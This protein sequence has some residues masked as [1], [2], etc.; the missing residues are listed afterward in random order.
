M[1]RLKRKTVSILVVL[2]MLAALLIPAAMPAAAATTSQT[3]SV[4][5]IVQP[6]YGQLTTI[7]ING[8][9]I[10]GTDQIQVVLPSGVNFITGTFS[11]GTNSYN[12]VPFSVYGGAVSETVTQTLST[13]MVGDAIWTPQYIPDSQQVP[14]GVSLI[15]VD[16]LQPQL[17]AFTVKSNGNGNG[18]Y[19]RINMP[20]SVTSA[21]SGP[22]QA[23]VQDNTTAVTAGKVTIGNAVTGGTVTTLTTTA[24]VA[25]NS[26]D[27]VS[28]LINE[29]SAGALGQGGGE[30][31][32]D[33]PSH[34]TW[35][36]PQITLAGGFPAGAVTSSVTTN[37]SGNSRMV[38]QV[39]KPS[40][41]TPGSILVNTKI[42]ADYNAPTGDITAT[43]GGTDP[44][45]T[46]T[47]A[48]VGTCGDYNVT[49]T[50]GN[51]PTIYDGQT[52]QTVGTFTIAESVKNTLITGRS[53]SLTLPGGVRWT[54]SNLP[55]PVV[56]TGSAQLLNPTLSSDRQTVTYEIQNSGGSATTF[57]FQQGEVD[58]DSTVTPGTLSVSI[59][60]SGV[61]QT[62][63][64]AKIASP[65]TA[66]A[67]G[68]IPDVTIG[69]PA[70]NGSDFTIT[71]AAAGAIMANYGNG[72]NQ[73]YLDIIAPS[74]VTF[75]SIP[76]IKVTS[77][78][79]NLS[80]SGATLT[81]YN[82]VLN[83]RISIPVSNGSNTASTITVSNV[84]LNIDNT[85]GVGPVSLVLGG[86]A[87][88]DPSTLMVK[89]SNG[90]LIPTGT[91]LVN[92]SYV[93]SVEVANCNTSIT[94]GT[95]G[96]GTGGTAVFTI[97][98]TSYTVNGRTYTMDVAP[99]TQNG[100]TFVP[101]RYAAMALGVNPDNILYQSG[102]VTVIKGS[103]VVQM[104]LGSYSMRINGADITMDV[105]VNT[106]NGRTMLPLRWLGMALGATFNW[107]AGTQTVT[108]SNQ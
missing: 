87:L 65:V 35:A 107:N 48:T 5:N 88:V 57:Q 74:G 92:G 62:V 19:V 20:V 41:G 99:Y 91:R 106:V 77:G 108:V 14:N 82:G 32:I 38:L 34:F 72:K 100:R 79:L 73:A 27:N 24:T 102:V 44:G 86:S 69:R 103:T 60:G 53:L 10:S 21:A 43:F 37:S 71:E 49:T 16:T 93:A 51:V 55:I 83:S 31:H 47:T 45:F 61:N 40:K 70:Q 89:D 94:T 46:A 84:K 75:A 26:S 64:I 63:D 7:K 78:D 39:V 97:G 29:N 33:L 85:V 18:G 8:L 42:S 3:D 12:S 4:P 9:S 95:G 13:P 2:A 67:T 1:Y 22:I 15:S 98:N 17:L 25:Q 11:D 28:F 76:T 56:Q 50:Q 52:G 58:V 104:T 80:P 54:E 81:D 66:T 105:P 23:I 90:N 96:T 101:L 36:T 6:Y 30:I 59:S 68:S